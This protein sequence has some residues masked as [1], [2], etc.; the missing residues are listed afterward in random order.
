M[1]KVFHL[2]ETMNPEDGGPFVST[3]LLLNLRLEQFSQHIIYHSIDG[4]SYLSNSSNEEIVMINSNFEMKSGKRFLRAVIR[5][6]NTY[7]NSI[8]IIHGVWDPCLWIPMFL[9]RSKCTVMPKGMLSPYSFKRKRILKRGLV[10]LFKFFQIN[11]TPTSKYESS[12]LSHL[13]LR[14]TGI[15]PYYLENISRTTGQETNIAHGLKILYMSRIDPKKGLLEFL[16]KHRRL[17]SNKDISLDVF[18]DGPEH[19]NKNCR[20]LSKGLNINFMGWFSGNK[21]LLYKQYDIFLLPTYDEN[22]SMAILEAL[23][24]GLAVLTTKQ[25]SWNLI[26][27]L[28]GLSTEIEEFDSFIL[29]CLEND[30]FLDNT[31]AAAIKTA[32]GYSSKNSSRALFEILSSL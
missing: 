2:I 17:F 23:S 19:Y 14:T 31:K 8:F 22:F 28:G 24:N 27:E 13:G 26:P 5:A 6:N 25:S 7:P 12:Q 32:L 15:L 9:L 29:K 10:Y 21:E 11:F 30:H 18:G 20:E 1:R 4:Q 16:K 3:Q